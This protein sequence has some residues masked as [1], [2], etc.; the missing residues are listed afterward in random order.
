MDIEKIVI[1]EMLCLGEGARKILIE[2][3]KK[4]NF[5]KA[6]ITKDTKNN[7]YQTN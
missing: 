5:H 6:L 2:E 7:I 4:K 3:I 1:N